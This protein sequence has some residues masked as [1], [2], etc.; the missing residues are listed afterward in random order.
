VRPTWLHALSGLSDPTPASAR[1]SRARRVSISRGCADDAVCRTRHVRDQWQDHVAAQGVDDTPLIDR[2]YGSVLTLRDPGGR[3]FE[4]FYGANHP[5]RLVDF[6][7]ARTASWYRWP[8]SCWLTAA[9]DAA[10]ALRH[11]GWD[12]RKPSGERIRVERELRFCA[13]HQA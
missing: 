13:P 10:P 9:L 4:M 12:I 5:E 7:A 6:G 8:R 1:R 3:Q 2:D 11:G